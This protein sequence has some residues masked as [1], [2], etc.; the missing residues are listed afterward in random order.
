[1]Q[2]E[3]RWPPAGA[4]VSISGNANGHASRLLLSTLAVVLPAVFQGSNFCGVSRLT[5]AADIPP[6][7]YVLGETAQLNEFMALFQAKK[8]TTGTEILLFWNVVGDTEVLVTPSAADSYVSAKPE[9]RIRSL[10]LCRG[11]FE[12]FLGSEPAVLAG[13]AVWA[14]GARSLLESD[15]VKRNTK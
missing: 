15:N 9:L 6:I 3:G 10:S 8:L 11:L 4:G 13:R 7:P 1:M 2:W 14:A 12:I 5:S